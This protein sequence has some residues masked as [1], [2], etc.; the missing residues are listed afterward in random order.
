MAD[1]TVNK[2]HSIDFNCKAQFLGIGQFAR[3]LEEMP[4]ECPFAISLGNAYFCESPLRIYPIKIGKN[5]G[6]KKNSRK[7]SNCIKLVG[8]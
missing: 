4:S 8:K 5:S 1:T 7:D 6:Y 3:C 2:M